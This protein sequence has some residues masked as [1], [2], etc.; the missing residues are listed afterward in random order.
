MAGQRT[1]LTEQEIQAQLA[2]LPGWAYQG[3]ALARTYKTNGWPSTL[4]LVNAIG[5]LAESLDHH[6]DLE[7]HWGSVG[8][9]LSTHS[10][11]G[12]TPMDVELARQ[13]EETAA[14]GLPRQLVQP[15]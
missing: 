2:R 9:R 14:R 3:G 10:A 6:P 11:G 13:I 1:A 12:V 4:M 8:I 7:V 15:S 5:F